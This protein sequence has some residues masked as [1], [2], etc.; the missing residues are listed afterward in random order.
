MGIRF[1]L[2]DEAR[3]GGPSGWRSSS[4]SSSRSCSPVNRGEAG[5][6]AA[7]G[8]P[9]AATEIDGGAAAPNAGMDDDA[10]A[11]IEEVDEL[12]RLAMEVDDVYRPA[13]AARPW[14]AA[15]PNPRGVPRLVS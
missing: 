4:S 2:C 15:S 1:H 11:A 6:G 5:K 14:L 12:N 9:A 10:R 8:R 7:L 13:T 3:G